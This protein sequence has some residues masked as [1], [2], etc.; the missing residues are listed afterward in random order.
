M[1][2]QVNCFDIQFGSQL[3]KN[4]QFFSKDESRNLRSIIIL[5]H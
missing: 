1:Y 4:W 5:N 2:L 3:F